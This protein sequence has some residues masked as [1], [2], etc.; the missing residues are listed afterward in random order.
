MF[1][2]RPEEKATALSQL[3]GLKQPCHSKIEIQLLI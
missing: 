2:H 3:T 1:G